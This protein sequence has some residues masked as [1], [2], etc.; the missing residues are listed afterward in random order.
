MSLFARRE[1]TTDSATMDMLKLSGGKKISPRMT[2]VV[3]Y[4]D[5]GCTRHAATY[6]WHYTTKPRKTDTRVMHNCVSYLLTWLPTTR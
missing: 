4:Y 6:P 3:L 1:P 5:S 2:D